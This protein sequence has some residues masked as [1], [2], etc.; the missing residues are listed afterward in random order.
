M[1]FISIIFFLLPLSISQFSS[2]SLAEQKTRFHGKPVNPEIP[3]GRPGLKESEALKKDTL[4]GLMRI[5]GGSLFDRGSL[6]PRKRKKERLQNL[7]VGEYAEINQ[8]DQPIDETVET[9]VRLRQRISMESKEPEQKTRTRL[10]LK[11]K[12][13]RE[14]K[15]T[16]VASTPPPPKQRFTV[17]RSGNGKEGVIVSDRKNIIASQETTK[18]KIKLQ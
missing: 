4:L 17:L 16:K 5:A 12:E 10:R 3:T 14:R 8:S 2:F 15:K 11:P 7:N 9:G 6:N 13:S 18:K 1:L